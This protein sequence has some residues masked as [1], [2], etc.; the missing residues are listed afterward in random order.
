MDKFTLVLHIIAHPDEY[1][2]DRLA[3]IM[4]DPETRQI[5]NLLCKV[6]SAVETEQP[7]DADAEW[8]RFATKLPRRRFFHSGSR[9][10]V[11]AAIMV[12]SVAVC[13]GITL[14]LN[15]WRKPES[16]KTVVQTE[17]TSTHIAPT[18]AEADTLIEPTAS[19]MFEDATLNTIMTVIAS[20]YGLEVKFINPEKSTLRLYYKFDNTRPVEHI[21]D[22]LNTFEQI[23]IS[24]EDNTLIVE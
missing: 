18:K 6:D 2:A 14:S 4:S 3:G 10:A 12:T 8:A 16:P 24:I 15:H 23:N 22:Q 19:V 7:V 21:I 9:A 11:I 5:Y 17:T 1:P 20:N 13:A